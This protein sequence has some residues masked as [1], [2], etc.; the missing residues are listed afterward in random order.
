MVRWGV[1]A[2]VEHAK[3]NLYSLQQELFAKAQAA[4]AKERERTANVAAE[5][6][7]QRAQRAQEAA[8]ADARRQEMQQRARRVRLAFLNNDSKALLGFVGSMRGHPESKPSV[9]GVQQCLQWGL[10]L[11]EARMQR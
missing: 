7:A 9:H 6:A 1:Q 10:Q 2:E 3:Q 4:E 5:Q 8:V 11:K